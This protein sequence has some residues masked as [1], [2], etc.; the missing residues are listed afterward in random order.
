M[1]FWLPIGLFRNESS[2]RC[3]R[4]PTTLLL[5]Q[6]S[7]VGF[8][9]VSFFVQ[10]KPPR[11]NMADEHVY[12]A[13][14]ERPLN[15]RPF[16]PSLSDLRLSLPLLCVCVCFSFLFFLWCGFVEGGGETKPAGVLQRNGAAL[17]NRGGGQNEGARHASECHLSV[18]GATASALPGVILFLS[19][20]PTYR[21]MLPC[22]SAITG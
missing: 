12:L 1:L 21:D 7:L 8:V 22:Y 2:N 6:R 20:H 4:Y 15:S 3:F 9:V 17:R 5:Q 18:K 13:R 10:D 14:S 11:K 19:C 16:A